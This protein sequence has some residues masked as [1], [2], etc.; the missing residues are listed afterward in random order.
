MQEPKASALHHRE[1]YCIIQVHH[2]KTRSARECHVT[3]NNNIIE[4]V[5]NII[6]HVRSY[7]SEFCHCSSNIDCFGWHPVAIVAACLPLLLL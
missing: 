1:R 5:Y 4:R 7:G 3:R 6:I 2:I